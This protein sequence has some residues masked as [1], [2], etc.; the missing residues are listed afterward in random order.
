MENVRQVFE[1][2][3]FPSAPILK[4]ALIRRN[5]EFDTKEV[6]ALVK[7]ETVRQVQ[8]PTYRYTG[9]IVSPSLNDL[10]FADLIDFTAAP[11]DGDK[12]VGLKPTEDNE[13]YILVV[14]RVFDRK[15]WTAA[16][17]NKRAETVAEAFKEILASI[18]AKVRKVSTDMG[19]EFGEAFKELMKQEGIL[20]HMK[21]KNDLH[22]IATIDVAIGNLK[23]ALARVSRKR[24]TDDW[25][26]LLAE[27][28]RG[29]NEIPNKSYLDEHAPNEVEGDEDLRAT[30]RKKNQ[31]FEE[32]NKAAREKRGQALETAGQFRVMMDTGRRFVRGFKP[33]WSDRVYRISRLD[34]AF[35]YDENGKEH[36]TKFVQP[37]T[38]NPETLQP[39]RIE[40]GG[41][42]QTAGFQRTILEDLASQA[43]RWIGDRTVTNLQLNAMLARS[44]FKE[45]AKRARINMRTP[46]LNFL[47]LFPDIFV[48]ETD[49]PNTLIR[50]LRAQPAFEGARRL[51]RRE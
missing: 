3:N 33:R 16:L 30:L 50:V 10:L 51:R 8:A 48:V 25:A 47:K 20:T 14:Q 27:V 15:L 29:Q 6:D 43:R 37:V 24:G 44:G 49:G 7:G 45:A 12:R 36:L 34:G 1:E 23:K 22:A 26:D 31:E 9:K 18:G 19:P 11:S 13:R 40:Q 42:V 4:R 46:V 2:L 35:V 21:R 5:I 39:R 38:G 41:S 17:R 32:I 28:T